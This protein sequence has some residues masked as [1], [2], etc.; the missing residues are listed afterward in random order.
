MRSAVFIFLAA[1]AAPAADSPQFRGPA[2]TGLAGAKLPADWGPGRHVKWK[3]A[4]PG[5]AW[6]CPIV[7][8]DKVLVTTAF[9]EGQPKP[10]SGYG[11]GRGNR[12]ELPVYQYKVVALDRATGELAWETTAREAKPRTPTHG[13]NTFASET[14]AS[15][16]ERVFAYFGNAGLYCY[17]LAGQLVWSKDLGA[18]PMQNGWGTSSSPIAHGGKVFIQCDNEQESFLAAFDAKTG[19]EVWRKPRPEKSGWSTPYL[20]TAAGR[21]D[22][23]VIGSQKIRGYNPADGAVAWELAVGGGQCSASPVSDGDYLY[24]G[25]GTGGGGRMR[26]GG[27]DDSSAAG[28]LFAVKPGVAGDITPKSGEST[29]AGVA[30]S[31]AKVW[32]AAASPLAYQ[33]KVYLLDRQGGM[34]SCFDAKTGKADYAR[35]RIPQAK[36]FWASPWASDGKVFCLDESGQTFVLKAG[37]EFEVERVNALGGELFWATPAAAGGAVFVRGVDHLYCVE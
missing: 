31:A 23:V 28:T 16:G 6:S 19:A 32:P 14:P 20:W 22:L 5:V 26:R 13:S 10:K 7:V 29:S 24:V 15:D 2:G 35:E 17:D 3:V 11:G 34:V 1:A 36:A 37:A 21:T 25:T 27:G 18:F 12:G 9:A 33:G 30:W 4:V 8:G